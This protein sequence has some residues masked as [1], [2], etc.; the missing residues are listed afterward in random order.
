MAGGLNSSAYEKV[1]TPA[2]LPIALNTKILEN[3]IV[4]TKD[5]LAGDSGL[6]RIWW[7]FTT[8]ADYIVTI[9]K[10]GAADLT[11]FPL[12]VNGDNTF[13]LKDN[14]YYRFD[15]GV[16]PGDLINLSSSVEITKVNDLQIQQIQI[17]A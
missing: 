9:T 1:S 16:K 7:S 13:I 17:G 8:G 5:L 2:G 11:G 15:I 14:G 6:F 3:D 12:I 10:K 4:V